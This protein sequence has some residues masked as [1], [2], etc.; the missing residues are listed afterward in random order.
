LYSLLL[1][2]SGLLLH[3]AYKEVIFLPTAFLFEL[4]LAYTNLLHVKAFKAYT[5]CRASI[6]SVKKTYTIRGGGKSCGALLGRGP[7]DLPGRSLGL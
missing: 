3:L 4:L 7:P 1:L 5:F 2:S 6:S